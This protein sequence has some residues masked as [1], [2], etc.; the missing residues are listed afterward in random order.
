M[1]SRRLIVNWRHEPTCVFTPV[2]E[3]VS[4]ISPEPKGYEFGYIEGV[5][6]ALS[7]GFAPFLSFPHLD[8]RYWGTELFP[9][10]RNRIMRRTRPDYAAYVEALG[11]S[12]QTANPIDLLGRSE[13][14]RQTDPFETVLA[15]ERDPKDGRYVT[16]FPV[17][18]VWKF[19]E[20]EA[21]RGRLEV[22]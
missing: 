6:G 4:V 22:G 9:F 20:A 12:V 15:A 10:F 16:R 8:R 2:A 1:R 13:G 17:R 14:R 19:A 18:A 7:R 3:L 5:R 21:V 11:L